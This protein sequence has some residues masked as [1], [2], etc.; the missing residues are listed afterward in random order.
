[1]ARKPKALALD[2]WSVLAYLE[3]EPAGQQ[4]ADLLAEAHESETPLMMTVVNAGEVWYILAREIS[5]EEADGSISELREL[6]VKFVDANWSLA[7]EAGRF[8]AKHKMSFADCFAVALAK[9]NR[10]DLVTG[11]PEFKQVEGEARILWLQAGTG[12]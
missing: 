4:V 11:D 8:K 5:V 7:R 6:G 3:D 1:M 12:A 10:A 9:E 2:S